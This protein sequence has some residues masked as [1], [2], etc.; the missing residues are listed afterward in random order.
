MGKNE[1]KEQYTPERF[2]TLKEELGFLLQ[3]YSGSLRNKF[4]RDFVWA[5]MHHFS[6]ELSKKFEPF[7]FTP[8]ITTNHALLQV[9]TTVNT[10]KEKDRAN[11][12]LVKSGIVNGGRLE[13]IIMNSG[14]GNRL[15]AVE[16][17]SPVPYTQQNY[18]IRNERKEE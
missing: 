12:M 10:K 3:I 7:P 16:P 14:E 6:E 9:I 4:P 13:V 11:D 8:Y 5:Q 18:T 15:Y 1:E 17:E 2:D